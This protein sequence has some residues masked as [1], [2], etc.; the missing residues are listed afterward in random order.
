[1]SYSS[2]TQSSWWLI[3]I[4]VAQN[5]EEVVKLFKQ[6][7][8]TTTKPTALT[9]ATAMNHTVMDSLTGR[10]EDSGI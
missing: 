1:M 6:A 3:I 4:D 8:K 2:I 9:K 5:F 7:Q 10:P